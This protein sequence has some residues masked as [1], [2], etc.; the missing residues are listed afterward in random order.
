MVKKFITNSLHQAQK[1]RPDDQKHPGVFS[2]FS[3]N[4]AYLAKGRPTRVAL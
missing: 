2:A 3:V 4:C 1:T